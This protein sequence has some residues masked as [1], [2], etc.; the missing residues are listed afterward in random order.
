[1]KK[2]FDRF[3][4]KDNFEELEEYQKKI[5]EHKNKIFRRIISIFVIGLAIVVCWGV[6]QYMRVYN[7]YVIL[8]SQKRS[9]VKSAKFE[10][11]NGN[12]LKYSQDG[13]SYLDLDSNEIWNHAYSMQDPIVSTREDYIAVAD[14]KGNKIYVLNTKG[15]QGEIKALKP[16]R[17]IRVA[18]QGVVAVLMEDENANYI[19][20]YDKKGNLLVD[21]EVRLENTGYPINIA[22]SND[23]QKLAV[24]YLDISEGLPRTEVAFYNFGSV[25]QEEVGRLVSSY[26]YEETIIPEIEFLNNDI[27]AAFGDNKVVLYEGA[28][29]PKEIKKMNIKQEIRSVFQNKENFGLVFENKDETRDTDK[30]YQMDLYNKSGEKIVTVDFDMDYTNIKLNDKRILLS[31]EKECSIFTFQGVEKFHYK[32]PDELVT[33]I[34]TSFD[35]QFILITSKETQR[36]QIK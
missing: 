32:F 28:Q 29:K 31:S 19:C 16:I 36:I 6:F 15:F 26:T 30:K 33:V 9:D 17:Q 4:K 11:F 14:Q 2:I 10:E 23:G 22:F 13:I 21:S 5:L 3:K 24:S 18:N 27:V 8:S 34:P 7:D 25:G 1:M 20:C 35:R 12:I